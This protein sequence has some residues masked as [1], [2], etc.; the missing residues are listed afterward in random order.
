M[1]KTGVVFSPN[2]NLAT[3]RTILQSIGTSN[4]K[5]YKKFLGLPTYIGRSKV[6]IFQNSKERVWG[7]LKGLKEKTL[8]NAG[9]EVLIKA[10]AQSLL[11]YSMPIFKLPVSLYVELNSIITN[12]WWGQ[13]NGERRI[14]WISWIKL[15]ESKFSG[16]L[17]FRDLHAFDLAMLAKQVMMKRI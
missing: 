12:S 6:S 13:K 5:S 17:G 10:I 11:T 14:N 15:C 16:G 3:R 8:S 2:T 9:K 1:D 7:K 4:D